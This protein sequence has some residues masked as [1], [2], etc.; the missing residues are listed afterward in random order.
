LT[1]LPGQI[2]P[3]GHDRISIKF[4]FSNIWMSI[5]CVCVITIAELLEIDTDEKLVEALVRNSTLDLDLDLD[6]DRIKVICHADRDEESIARLWKA[7]DALNI[8]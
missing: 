4:G 3:K 5:F 1:I 2:F 8:I 6:L 7:N